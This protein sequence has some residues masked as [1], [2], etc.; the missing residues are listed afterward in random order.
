MVVV[1]TGASRGIGFSIANVF[2]THGNTLLLT[3]QNE[4]RL[5]Q[6]TA[7]L[8]NSGKANIQF[9]AADLSS[10]EGC[11]AF[12]KFVEEQTPCIDMLVNN[13]GSFLPGS[14]HAEA[15]GTL[16]KMLEVNLLS[17]YRLSRAFVPLLKNS[18]NATLLNVSSIAALSAYENGG[19]YS[20]SKHALR[21]MS[22]NLRQELMPLGIKVCCLLPGATY[23]DS[24]MHSGLP[25]ER[26]IPPNDLATLVHCIAHLSP[27]TCVE[28]LV[29]RPIAG[30][31]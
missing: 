31:I 24:W 3:G 6:A 1:I 4:E 26:F 12:I 9:R 11:N 5:E 16:E 17:A 30:D 13:A 21:G 14:V 29:V 25:E 22:A 2:N 19:S 23:T 18:S 10:Q 27:Q 8:R 15:V 7:S 28:E 20:I